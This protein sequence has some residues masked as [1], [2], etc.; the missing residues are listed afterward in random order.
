VK[1]T[2]AFRTVVLGIATL[3]CAV[4]AYP[5]AI[6]GVVALVNG[7]PVTFSEVREEVAGSLGIPVGDA[8]VFL[9]QEKDT[10]TILRW[11]NE[12]VEEV[13]VRE[14]LTKKGHTVKETDV[15]RAIESIRQ[16]NKVDEKQF[17]ELLSKEGLSLESYR[18]RVR[19]QLERGAIVRARKFKEVVVTEEEV[20]EYYRENVERFLVGSEVRLETMYFPIPEGSP[21]DAAV[22][23]RVAA[24][25]AAAAIRPGRPLAD[26]LEVARMG[27]PE[28]RILSGD[29]VPSKDL[30]PQMRREIGRLRTGEHSV[31]FFAG[32]GV[33]IVRVVERRGG[34]P[35]E[36][37]SVKEALT[38]ELQDRRSEKAYADIIAELKKAASIDVRL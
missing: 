5:R 13:L 32:S 6:D 22:R 30:L 34:K 17:L 16:S 26:G 37:S 8:D 23:A 24:S 15:D 11:I 3:L 25:H 33:Y 29:F 2:R 38:E 18:R 10:G 36:F 27:F 20:R 9:R 31:P 7:E 12:L 28:A 4:P 19:W 14:E 1:Q 35:M 21:E